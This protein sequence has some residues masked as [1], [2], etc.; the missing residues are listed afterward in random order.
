MTEAERIANFWSWFSQN[1]N[2][3]AH[4]AAQSDDDWLRKEMTP[5]VLN[6]LPNDH[7]GP[8]I[9]WQIGPSQTRK[10]QFCLSPLV[11]Q[12]LPLTRRAASEAP[13][14]SDW[15]ILSSKPPRNSVRQYTLVDGGG[16][17]HII[18]CADMKYALTRYPGGQFSF[19]LIGE[20]PYGLDAADKRKVAYLVIEGALGEEF[21]LDHVCGVDLHDA[22]DFDPSIPTSAL[23]NVTCHL[24]Q[25]LER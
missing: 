4:A 1:Q 15:E 6:L 20:L 16:T 19:D 17:E 24:S 3:I 23:T 18:C 7:V 22:N 12:N 13:L 11:K 8:R 25:L 10:W 5:R 14:L 2:A 21:M 9:N